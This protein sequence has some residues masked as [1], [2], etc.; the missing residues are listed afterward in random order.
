MLRKV[1][2]GS[3]LLA[4]VPVA[5]STQKSGGGGG[6]GGGS[7]STTLKRPTELSI[8]NAAEERF[9]VRPFCG[10]QFNSIDQLT[11]MRL[12]SILQKDE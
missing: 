8:Y 11:S 3:M 7:D 1:V 12:Y 2:T 9:E 5:N 6:G 4:A 10:I